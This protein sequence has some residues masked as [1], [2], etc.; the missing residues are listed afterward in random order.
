MGSMDAMTKPKTC[1]WMERDETSACDKSAEWKSP[2]G[3]GEYFLC[4][5][6]KDELVNGMNNP[7]AEEARWSRI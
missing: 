1:E 7:T 6:H 4:T 2:S 5:E 3:T